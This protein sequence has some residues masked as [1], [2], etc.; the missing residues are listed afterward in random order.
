MPFEDG[1]GQIIIEGAAVL[2]EQGFGLRPERRNGERQ[3]GRIPAPLE[4]A[5]APAPAS[6]E[7]EFPLGEVGA[8]KPFETLDSRVD[9]DHRPWDI[10]RFKRGVRGLIQPQP[11]PDVA[12]EREL[13]R[14][15]LFRNPFPIAVIGQARCE[16]GRERADFGQAKAGFGDNEFFM[17][18]YIAPAVFVRRL[19]SKIRSAAR[20]IDEDTLDRH[21]LVRPRTPVHDSGRSIL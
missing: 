18:L 11:A 14:A 17:D 15:F 7:P 20:G 19:D 13:R 16:D 9:E 5:A 2:E 1:K 8:D 10:G 6:G 3:A 4:Q 12:A 21:D